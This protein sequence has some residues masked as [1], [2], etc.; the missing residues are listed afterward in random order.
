MAGRVP[1]A[2]SKLCWV[3][4][5]LPLAFDKYD[6]SVQHV[7]HHSAESASSMFDRSLPKSSPI[8][9]VQMQEDRGGFG[10]FVNVTGHA[11]VHKY[12]FDMSVVCYP[13]DIQPV[14]SPWYDGFYLVAF[15]ILLQERDLRQILSGRVHRVR[16][17][18]RRVEYHR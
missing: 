13:P 12:G 18:H 10:G 14:K 1:K 16:V 7:Q 6:N 9:G 2:V 15:P 11:P 5:E 3:H 17:L 4:V 8:P